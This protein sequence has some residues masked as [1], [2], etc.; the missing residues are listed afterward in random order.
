MSVAA[1]I[2]AESR[3]A[4]ETRPVLRA[5]PSRE[6]GDGDSAKRQ[7]VLQPSRA[8]RAAMAFREAARVGFAPSPARAGRMPRSPLP[9]HSRARRE[10]RREW[11]SNPRYGFPYGGFQDRCHQPLGHPSADVQYRTGCP[12]EAGAKP[13]WS[14]SPPLYAF[15]CGGDGAIDPRCRNGAAADVSGHCARPDFHGARGGRPDRDRPR[16]QPGG[17]GGFLADVAPDDSCSAP[18]GPTF[19][20]SSAPTPKA[21]P[22][23]SE[24]ER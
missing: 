22:R 3:R 11:D 1:M 7:S 19:R 4:C 10:W 24:A 2:A 16:L 6:S 21:S 18:S 5:A 13:R 12:E 8:A 23:R 17:G 14:E 15:P 9:P 20:A